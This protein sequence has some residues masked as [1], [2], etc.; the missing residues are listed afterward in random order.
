LSCGCRF[1][2][3]AGEQLLHLVDEGLALEGLGDVAVRVNCTGARFVEGLE[4]AREEQDGDVPQ[5]RIGLDG[6]AELVPVP[7]RHHDVGEDDVRLEL[8]RARDG[9]LSVVDRGDLEVFTRERDAH[10]LLDRD[11]V[12]REEKVLGH[13]VPGEIGG[14]S[15]PDVEQ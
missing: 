6:F 11:G 3:R 10:D 1:R 13:G 15:F 12:I 9:V 8:S 2:L 7:L 4:R 14:G 5:R